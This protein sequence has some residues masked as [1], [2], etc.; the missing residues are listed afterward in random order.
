M[1]K[2]K[3]L[4]IR[5]EDDIFLKSFNK[6]L[7]NEKYEIYILDQK[8]GKIIKDGETYKVLNKNISKYKLIQYVQKIVAGIKYVKKYRKIEYDIIHLLNIKIENYWLL[9]ILK[10]NTR[11][12][13][14]SVYGKT[15]YKNPVKR[16][17]FQ[18]IYNIIDKIVFTNNTMRDE[19]L[20]YNKKIKYSQTK[21]LY[22]PISHMDQI[23]FNKRN[24][25]RN[26]YCK[27]FNLNPDLIHIS[28][29]S[30][31]S[32][33]DQHDKIINS[34]TKIKN[35]EK[36]ELM[37]LLSYGGTPEEKDN[38]INNIKRELIDFNVCIVDRYLNE[39]EISAYR[40]L[41]DIYINMRSTDQLAGAIIE[42][43]LAGALLISAKWLNYKQ[44]DDDNIFYKTVD[45][46][47]MLSK[48]IDSSIDN[49]SMIR[50]EYLERNANI[51]EKKYNIDN[52]MM[53]WEEMYN[54]Y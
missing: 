40:M 18:N 7:N 4:Y 34:L 42:S 24:E 5:R 49:Y 1:K 32:S 27:L 22:L 46:F 37:F 2:I 21:I 31:I 8:N 9:R 47:E 10:K 25:F 29:S 41:T 13:I 12:I 45:N 26:E 50:D 35:K 33:Y 14:I 51:L 19:F 44:L 39:K 15:T 6:Y 11:K 36:V 16:I 52:I 28:C 3:I 30:T 43:M 23:S 53:N 48:C 54:E 17:L 38:I 20:I